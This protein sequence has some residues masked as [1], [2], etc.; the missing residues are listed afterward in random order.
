M[1]LQE[2]LPNSNILILMK[3]D[4]YVQ[5]QKILDTHHVRR[6]RTVLK[7]GGRKHILSNNLETN[8]YKKSW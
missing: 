5:R 6:V 8:G 2:T 4:I 1:E 7:V 3:V